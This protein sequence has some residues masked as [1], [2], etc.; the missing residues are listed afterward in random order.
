MHVLLIHQAFAGPDDPGGTRHYEIGCRLVAQG[1]RFTVITSAVNYLTGETASTPAATLPEG[2]RVIRLTGSEDIHRSYVARARGFFAF[3]GRA[4]RAALALRDVHVVWGT[5]PPLV[6]LVPAWLA[7]RRCPGGFVLEERDLWPEFAVGMGVVRD[8]ALTRAALRFKR[9]LYGRARRVVINSPGFL[10]F[11][12][13]YGVPDEKI[14][15]IPNGVDVDH[16]DPA[17]RGEALRRSWGAEERFV[18]LYAGALGPA[19]GLEVVLDAAAVLRGTSALFVLVGDGKA[20]GGLVASAAAR[21]LDNVC[22]VP[23]QPKRAMREVLGAADVCLATLRDIPLFRTTYPNKVFDYMAAG[24]P[25]LLGIDG[26][27][28]DVVERARA[29]VFVAPGDA[30]ALSAAVRRLMASRDEARAMGARGRA[31]VCAEFDRRKQVAGFEVLLHE[32]VPGGPSRAPVEAELGGNMKV[33][34]QR[35]FDLAVTTAML[36]VALLLMALSG[37]LVWLSMGSPVLF[38][39]TRTGL[40]GRLFTLYKFRTMRAGAPGEPDA[41]R[42]TTI[43]RLIRSLSLDELPQL[44]NVLRGDMSVVGPRPLLPQYLGRYT[45]EQTRRH[46]VRP[47]ITGLAQVSGRNALTWDEKFALDVWYADHRNVALDARILLRTVGAVVR[48][49]GVSAPGVATMPEFMGERGRSETSH[50]SGCA[51][52]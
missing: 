28:R 21:G 8:G 1:H 48:R 11:L 10:P 12:S 20:R 29:G 23:A 33:D 2:M 26:V 17:M 49:S 30:G 4:L 42:L 6:Q 15:I 41:V 18:V 25:V 47:G 50:G 35:L 5:S 46:E 24:R 40:H 9:F 27:I 45:P 34:G 51:T 38:R 13:G 3:S 32:L 19:N 14:R 37:L 44:W 52:R 31:A 22:F 7:S 43:G 36:P 39:H 16:F